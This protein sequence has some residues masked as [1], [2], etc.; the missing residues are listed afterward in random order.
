MNIKYTAALLAAYGSLLS[1]AAGTE[2]PA[3][4]F[5][6]ASAFTNGSSATDGFQFTVNSPVSVSSLG[7]WDFNSDGLVES[8]M[9]A[10]FTTSGTIVASANVPGG[11]GATLLDGF[12]YVSILPTTL[13][14]GIYNIGAFYSDVPIQDTAAIQAQ[15]FSTD[16]RITFNGSR[17]AGGTSLT[18][19]TTPLAGFDPGIFGPNFLLTTASTVPENGSTLPLLGLALVPFVCTLKRRRPGY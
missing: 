17:A 11:T 10:I 4:S 16:P 6:S 2:M 5:T 12:R 9:V 18:N 14:P 3:V 7:I 19:P 8:H 1:L 15:G 13:L